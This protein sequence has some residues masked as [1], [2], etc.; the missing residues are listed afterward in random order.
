M[1][2]G[3]ARQYGAETH[4]LLDPRP[5]AFIS[6]SIQGPD[7]D[8]FMAQS[9]TGEECIQR[10]EAPEFCLT[11]PH[12]VMTGA[13]DDTTGTPGEDRRAAYELLPSGDKYLFWNT[14][15]A[16]R[17]TVFQ[18]KADSCFEYSGPDSVD[19]SRCRLYLLWQ[20]SAILAFLD[21][22]IHEDTAAYEYLQ[23][24]NI[25]ILSE[26]AAEFLRK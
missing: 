8:G 14:E 26:S 18:H 22:Y 20:R 3:A 10:A 6:G 15:E 11:R 21:A 12:L 4:L 25:Q 5:I 13:G 16:A 1:V 24:D 9:Y 17:H 2:A 7:D 23:S 19:A